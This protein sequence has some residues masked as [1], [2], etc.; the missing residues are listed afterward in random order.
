VPL[1]ETVQAAQ[2]ID[3]ILDVPGVDAIF[4]GPHDFAASA[5]YP[6]A[7]E[8]PDIVEQLLQIQ[9]RVSERKVASGIVAFSKDD[10][11]LRQKQGFGM[12]ALGMD[13]GLLIRAAT[14]ALEIAGKP[15]PPAAWE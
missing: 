6:G 9:R 2:N 10:I 4:F 15:V 5:G 3:A 11:A 12:I 14:E 7:W 8:Q 1:L 13:T